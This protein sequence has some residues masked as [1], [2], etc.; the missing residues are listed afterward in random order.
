MGSWFQSIFQSPWKLP[1]LLII[2]NIIAIVVTLQNPE[3][4]TRTVVLFVA[5]DVAGIIF[6]LL[7]MSVLAVWQAIQRQTEQLRR[8]TDYLS[9]QLQIIELLR[10]QLDR[11]EKVNETL[12]SRIE[13]LET[14]KPDKPKSAMFS[15]LLTAFKRLLDE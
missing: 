5:L 15:K 8:Q 9:A 10:D 6:Q 3:P 1:P 7:N 13:V 4:L 2:V 12:L 14:F 11:H